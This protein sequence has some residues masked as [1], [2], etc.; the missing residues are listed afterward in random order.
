[1]QRG[2]TL[3][4]LMI[5]VAIIGILAAVALPAYQDY[6]VRS[7]VSEA[8]VALDAAKITVAENAAN[9]LAFATGYNAGVATQNI[10]TV[11]TI[12]AAGVITVVTSAKAGSV[13]VNMTPFDGA[14][15]T[16]L[17]VGTPPTNQIV[18]AC[19]SAAGPNK[20]LPANCR[21]ATAAA[22]L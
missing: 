19:W 15:G 5:V 20:Y 8:V 22:L 16:A 4:E 21:Q 9:G 13:T 17:T 14:V 18:W 3:I 6:T 10:A 12:S 1:M 11:P 2:F 7:R